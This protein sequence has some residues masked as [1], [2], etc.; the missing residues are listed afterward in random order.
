VALVGEAEKV[1]MKSTAYILRTRTAGIWNPMV[2]SPRVIPCGLG[3][4]RD[5]EMV[6]AVGQA[7]RDRAAR[8][9]EI[10]T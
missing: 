5:V 3:V 10:A 2:Q 4:S 7:W 6:P 8:E 1:S 9:S